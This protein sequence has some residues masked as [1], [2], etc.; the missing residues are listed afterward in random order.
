MVVKETA[1]SIIY[2]I[3]KANGLADIIEYMAEKD[4]SELKIM[5]ENS[6]VYC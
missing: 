1:C 3:G 6:I 2:N 5:S 4:K